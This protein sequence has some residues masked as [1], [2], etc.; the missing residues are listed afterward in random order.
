MYHSSKLRQDTVMKLCF[1]LCSASL[2]CKSLVLF[3]LSLFRVREGLLLSRTDLKF[4]TFSGCMTRRS[5]TSNPF[6]GKHQLTRA[7]SGTRGLRGL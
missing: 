3:G 7:C 6:L 1:G 4:S 5:Q 2:N